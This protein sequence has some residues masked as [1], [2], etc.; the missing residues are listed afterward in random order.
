MIRLIRKFFLFSLFFIITHSVLAQANRGYIMG[1]GVKVGK[2]SSGASGKFFFGSSNSVALEA[3][4]TVKKNFGTGMATV[5]LEYQKPFFNS[6]LQIPLDYFVAAGTHTAVYKPGYYKIRDGNK[7]T[8][9][10]SGISWGLDAKIGLEYPWPIAP[11]T[12]SIEASP[13]I[14][15]VNRGPERLEIAFAIRYVIGRTAGTGRG[16]RAGR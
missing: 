10:D 12:T 15:I 6:L 8:Y 7:D 13:M 5:F 4:L 14:D 2:F 1:M 11:I 9:F 16:L 3:N